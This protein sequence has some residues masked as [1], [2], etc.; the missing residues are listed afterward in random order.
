MRLQGTN[1]APSE[2]ASQQLLTLAMVVSLQ[3]EC[4]WGD[5]FQSTSLWTV[6]SHTSGHFWFVHS[7]T[8]LEYCSFPIPWISLDASLDFCFTFLLGRFFVLLCCSVGASLEVSLSLF[9]FV[10]LKMGIFCDL[11]AVRP[12]GMPHSV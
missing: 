4:H 10:S 1:S 2:K 9:L 3:H 6:T 12:T 11:E 5:N 7:R 8:S